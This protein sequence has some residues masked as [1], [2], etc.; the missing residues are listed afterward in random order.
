MKYNYF[1]INGSIYRIIANKL[2]SLAYI[3]KNN[4]WIEDD[5][6]YVAAHFEDRYDFV[7]LT[8]EEAK[9]RLGVY[10]E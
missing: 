10:Y 3:F 4:K 5:N 6:T 7:I 9:L 1:D 8:Q 2:H